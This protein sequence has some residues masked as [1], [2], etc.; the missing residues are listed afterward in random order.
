MLAAPVHRKARRGRHLAK[1]AHI[2][3]VAFG[4]AY[5][6]LRIKCALP[7][8]PLDHRLDLDRRASRRR[9][10][11]RI[12][13]GDSAVRPDLLRWYLHEVARAATGVDGYEQAAAACLEYGDIEYIAHPHAYAWWRHIGH[14]AA[15]PR[16]HV[17]RLKLRGD[18][19]INAHQ[20]E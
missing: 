6:D 11:S 19:R 1:D 4:E 13:H 2:V 15:K 5:D 7:Q 8:P 9:D 18:T 10:L 20:S 14:E 17:L 3:G 16:R 12:R